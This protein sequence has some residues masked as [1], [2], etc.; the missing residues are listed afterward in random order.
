[1]QEPKFKLLN[2]SHIGYNSDD[3]IYIQE[4]L[5]PIH[6]EVFR[7]AMQLKKSNNISSVYTHNGFVY[8]KLAKEGDSARVKSKVHLQQ[9]VPAP[10]DDNIT[11]KRKLNSSVENEQNLP[12]SSIIKDAKLFKSSLTAHSVKNTSLSHSS[13]NKGNELRSRSRL[14]STGSIGTLD[15]YILKAQPIPKEIG[16]NIVL[17]KQSSVANEIELE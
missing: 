15:G 10:S 1:M 17:D 8:I 3:R 4:S 14:N 12:S 5:S 2:L 16:D 13:N 7:L 11:N 6:A 9:L